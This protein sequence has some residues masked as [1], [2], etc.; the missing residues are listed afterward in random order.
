MARVAF[1]PA[2]FVA[3]ALNCMCSPVV[4]AAAQQSDT[5]PASADPGQLDAEAPLDAM[6][7]IGVAWPDMAA[8]VAGEESAAAQPAELAERRYKVVLEGVEALAATPVRER[9]ET[10]STLKAGE[11]SAANSAQIQRRIRQD[12]ALLDTVLRASGHYDAQIDSEVENAAD[13]TLTV[14]MVVTAGPLY[15]FEN[16]QISGL[17]KAGDQKEAFGA[18][19]GIEAQDAVDADD[20]TGGATALER[21]MR[22]S[23][24]PFAK[25]GEPDI[26][27]DHETRN[28]A[29][30]L[31]IDPGGK[32]NFGAI[33]VAGEK[34]PFGADHVEDIARFRT[35]E[36]YNQTRLDDL[37]RALIATG[38]V[39][40]VSVDPVPASDPAL[41]DVRVVM[42]PAPLRSIAGELGYGTGEGVRAEASWTHRNLIGPEGAVTLRGVAGTREQQAYAVLHKPNFHKRDVVLNA[43]LG[44]SNINRSAYDARTVELGF[45]LERQ[46]NIIWHKRWTWSGGAELVATDERDMTA[47]LLATARRTYLIA[48]AP[49][50]LGYD[51]SNDLLDP[52]RGFRL[53]L[54]VSPELSLRKGTTGYVRLQLDGSAYLPASSKVVVAGRVRFG[55]IAGASVLD[56]AP[57]RRFYAGGGSSVRGYGYQQIGPR[58]AANDPVGGRSLAEFSLEA[59][60]RWREFGIVPFVDGGN[61]YSG[62]TPR[63]SGFRYGAGLGVRYH[64]S[65]GPIRV[66]VGTPINPRKGD[67][68]VT[69]FVS[70]GQAF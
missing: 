21:T 4:W 13:G 66:D 36:P 55:S 54:R 42:E 24:Y 48:A 7:D 2:S 23:G 1:L 69:V 38:V 70:L 59:R 50:T 64:S 34:P 10:L 26:L 18:I 28:A 47:G 33:M 45:G 39:G 14:R 12:S 8:P 27:L 67:T 60:V 19:L 63:L 43:R 56:L 53:G 9:F 65:F 5:P 46:S 52:T 35:G 3:L 51:R 32:R 29:L 25:V 31:D 30:A 58:D 61:I 41:A 62:Q 16:V 17:D 68:P 15:R 57:S 44:A 22:Q 37:R 11:K 49:A 6:P 20:V 40:T